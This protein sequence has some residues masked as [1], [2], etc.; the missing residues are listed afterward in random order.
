MGY[1]TYKANLLGIDKQKF[2]YVRKFCNSVSFDYIQPYN[3]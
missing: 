2:I 3:N 1:D